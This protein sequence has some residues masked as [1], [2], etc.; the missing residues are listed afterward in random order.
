[1]NWDERGG[2]GDSEVDRDLK[3]R[4][5]TQASDPKHRRSG[6]GGK[7]PQGMPI[8]GCGSNTVVRE[9]GKSR[10]CFPSK[11]ERVRNDM[12]GSTSMKGH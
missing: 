1:M 2:K 6:E 9:D 10:D 3:H 11:R 7:F 5:R 4:T 8:A 12:G